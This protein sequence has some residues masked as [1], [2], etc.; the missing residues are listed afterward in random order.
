MLNLYVSGQQ[1]SVIFDLIL[2]S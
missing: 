1:I 2:L